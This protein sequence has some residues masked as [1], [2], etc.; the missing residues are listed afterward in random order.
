MELLEHLWFYQ[1]FFSY[2]SSF[3]NEKR[4]EKNKIGY[5]SLLLA[6]VANSMNT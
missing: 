6:S 5:Y 3:R 4:T 2:T 1:F